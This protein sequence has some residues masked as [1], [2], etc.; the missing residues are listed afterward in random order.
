[1]HTVKNNTSSIKFSMIHQMPLSSPPIML[2]APT[3]A[4]SH[5]MNLQ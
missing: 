5:A 4:S 3:Q 2:K 1:M